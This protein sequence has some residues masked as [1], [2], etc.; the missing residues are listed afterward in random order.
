MCDVGKE[1]RCK[2]QKERPPR[3]KSRASRMRCGSPGSLSHK[4]VGTPKGSCNLR[5]QEM[6]ALDKISYLR[7]N[8]PFSLVFFEDCVLQVA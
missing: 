5:I 4:V 6:L 8:E 3:S 1:R 7:E 2:C